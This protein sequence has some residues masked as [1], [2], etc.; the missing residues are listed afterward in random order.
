[1]V[2]GPGGAVNRPTLAVVNTYR[3]Y[4]GSTLA[5]KA[6]FRA[7]GELGLGPTW[8]Q[9]VSSRNAADWDSEGTVV[10]G[11]TLFRADLNLVLN[12]LFVFPRRLAELREEVVFLTDPI[13]LGA[14][15]RLKRSIV[16]VHD[17]R[18]FGPARRSWAAEQVYRR[19]FRHIDSAERLV[20]VSAATRDRL[21]EIGRP[22]RPIEVLPHC[23]GLRGDPAGHLARSRARLEAVRTVR[24]LYLSADREYKNLPMF[25][26]LAAAFREPADGLRYRFTLVSQLR[27]STRRLVDRLAL[28]NLTV[29]P[30][31]PDLAALYEATDVLVHPSREE[32]FG[33]PLAEA[34]QFG[35]PIL[36]SNI[37]AVRETL[38]PAGTVLPP[39]DLDGWAAALR[40]LVDPGRFAAAARA[41]ADR[42][43]TYTYE[44]FLDR[45]RA[46]LPSWAA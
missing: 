8:V 25:C 24:V 30:E 44:S 18:E 12:A 1:M 38:G 41:S 46:W 16:L 34:M 4:T 11:T 45:V 15:P 21:V 31:V 37:P 40:G 32:G 13:L 3:R 33:L 26:R 22:D 23:A 2:H 35:I 7:F 10:R 19:L 17:L 43:R 5:A 6:Y 42:G 27:P 29:V 36:G 9:C 14:C 28:P 39:D 20:C